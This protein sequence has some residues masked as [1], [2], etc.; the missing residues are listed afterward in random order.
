MSGDYQL[1]E[2][3]NGEKTLLS[4]S[5][6]EKMHPGAGGEGPNQAGRHPQ[7]DEDLQ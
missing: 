7:Q 3:A 4:A 1:V 5:F 6:G 2:L